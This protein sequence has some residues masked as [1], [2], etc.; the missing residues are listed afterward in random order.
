MIAVTHFS[1]ESDDAF[2]PAVE[3]ALITLAA[4]AGYLRG[5]AGRSTDGE[6]AWVLVTEWRTVGDYRRA[7]G[8]YDVKLYA[9]PVLA[10]AVDLPGA[11]EQLVA[12]D[13]DGTLTRVTSDL[14]YG[15]RIQPS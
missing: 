15:E 10:Q 9:T 6:G 8:N 11:F 1:V 2:A 14:A 13:P 4:R 5:S 3:R 12:V 7:L